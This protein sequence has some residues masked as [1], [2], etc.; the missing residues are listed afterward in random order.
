MIAGFDSKQELQ[1]YCRQ[2]GLSLI[3]EGNEIYIP[4]MKDVEAL[5]KK[6]TEQFCKILLNEWNLTQDINKTFERRN[7]YLDGSYRR[8]EGRGTGHQLSLIR[9]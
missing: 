4:E 8:T 3:D 9:S 1:D 2:A 7:P 5:L 6:N